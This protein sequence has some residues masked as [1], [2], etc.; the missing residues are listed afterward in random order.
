MFHVLL[1]FGSPP[2]GFCAV[3]LYCSFLLCKRTSP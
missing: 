2:L 3:C 1:L